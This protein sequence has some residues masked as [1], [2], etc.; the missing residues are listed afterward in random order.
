MHIDWWVDGDPQSSQGIIADRAR[1]CSFPLG[2]RGNDIELRV[3]NNT[4]NEDFVISQIYLDFKALGAK[5]A[6]EAASPSKQMGVDN[7]SF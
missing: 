3:Y 1:R 4:A 7:V 5:V 6:G 2:A